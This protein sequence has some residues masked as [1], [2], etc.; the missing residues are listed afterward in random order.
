MWLN[1]INHRDGS[2]RM[3]TTKVIGQVRKLTG[4]IAK[5]TPPLTIQ[6]IIYNLLAQAK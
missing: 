1:K 5:T 2:A 4:K 3:Y 6:R